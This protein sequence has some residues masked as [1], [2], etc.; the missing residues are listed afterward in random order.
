[1]AWVRATRDSFL[2]CMSV[3]YLFAFS[4]FY[5]QIPGLLGDNGILPARVIELEEVNSFADFFRGKPT[6]LRLMPYLGLSTEKGM[7]FLCLAGIVLSF[8]CMTVKYFMNSIEYF[9]LWL[10]YL[11]LYQVGQTFFYFQ[12]DILL[13]EAGFLCILIAPLSI[14][15]VIWE[16][17]RYHHHDNITLFLVKWLLFRLMFASGVVK[18]T[19]MCPTWWGL[20]ALDYHFES[21]CIPTPLSWYAHHL[22]SW[23]LHLGVT[24]TFLIEI[25]I[26]FLFF[27]PI[28]HLRRFAFYSQ[29]LLQIGIILTGNYNFFNLLTITLCVS[30]LDDDF[31]QKRKARHSKKKVLWYRVTDW[32][33]TAAAYGYIIYILVKYF[34]LSFGPD[35]TTLKT[36]ITF[37]KSEFTDWLAKVV[38][39][40]I[41]IGAISLGIEVLVSLIRCWQTEKGFFRKLSSSF[42]V[43]LMAGVASC[44]FLISLVPYTVLDVKSN[45][46]LKPEIKSWYR[47]LDHLHLTSSYGLFRVMTGVG[48]RP[49]VIIEGSKDMKIWKEYQFLYKPG[50]VTER[51]VFVA[52]HQPRLDWQM[53]FAALGNY[54]HNPWLLTF[55]YRLLTGQPEVLELIRHNPFPHAPPKY[56]RA[57]LYHYHYTSP[58]QMSVRYS[59]VD[60]WARENITEYLPILVENDQGLNEWL[61]ENGIFQPIKA[62][63]S[64]LLAKLLTQIR[65]YIGQPDGFTFIMSIFSTGLTINFISKYFA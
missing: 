65:Q 54:Q 55:C 42:G 13:L 59:E 52:P 43:C 49:E 15:L 2:W 32:V 31:F 45:T 48:G 19:S 1:M 40:T 3:M 11:S 63:P 6:L 22:P 51:P 17:A 30:L 60:W 53:W 4:S 41:I 23:L 57:K 37:T 34:G 18:L 26:P 5:V 50:N 12:W 24:A 36:K 64:N 16:T 46:N 8:L 47:T 44:M 56:L 9:F 20:T 39:Y 10:L 27:A 14:N 7:E 33:L 25:V 58:K 28:K 61:L 21:Q 29:L 62:V 35:Y 38:P